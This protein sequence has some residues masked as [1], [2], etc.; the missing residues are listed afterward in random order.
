MS[1]TPTA[2]LLARLRRL[3]A[4]GAAPD[5]G[6]LPSIRELTGV[7]ERAKVGGLL[8]GVPARLL[9]GEG[10]PLRPLRV[11][12]TGTFT[13]DG[14]L[15]L[16]RTALLSAGIDAEILLTGYGRLTL[17]LGDPASPLAGFEPDV[18]LCLLHDEALLPHDWDPTDLA[19]LDRHV[20]ARAVEIGDLAADFAART[21]ATMLLHTV[22]L[23]VLEYRSL[24]AQRSRAAL[25]R[26]WRRANLVLLDLPERTQEVHVL[27]LE[28][29][30]ANEPVALRDE[31][32]YRF[33]RMAWSP[34][35]EDLYATEAAA[36]CRALTGLSRKVLALDLDQT[37]W[38]GVVGDDGPTGI[39]LGPLYPG[40][41]YLE[42][43][44][45]AK[46]LRRQGVLLAVCSKN[47]PEPVD[48]VFA[49]HP[50][51]VLQAEDFVAQAVNWLPK[52]ENLRELAHS[53]NLG[54]DSMVFFDDSAFE[55]ELVREALPDVRV[56]RANG[57]PADHAARLLGTG[58]FDVVR[59]TDTDLER[60]G[61]YRAEVRRRDGFAA[62]G[63]TRDFLDSL[64]LRVRVRPADPYAVP[65]V[66]Q[67]L[68]RTNQFNTTN[69]RW[70]A[71]QI[72][73]AVASDRRTVLVFDVADR[74]GSEDAVGAVLLSTAP[75]QWT[76]DNFVMS[77]RVFSRGIEFAVL[78]H[79]AERAA[80]RG[81]QRLVADFIPT[82]RNGPAAAF[83]RE[84]GF[85]PV[86]EPGQTHEL[87]LEPPPRPAPAWID[88][89]GE[90]T[91]SR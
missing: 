72:D 53:L 27:D 10:R 39:E 23:S 57:D 26:A 80:S 7:V 14:L 45:R 82:A 19:V 91:R 32:R 8:A 5:P 76:I 24:V 34:G 16:L 58:L 9:A 2:D 35:V 46:M 4:D 43:Q 48:R 55:C 66:H 64:E 11:G 12:L 70:T 31:R 69:L 40:N 17:D 71:A 84:A 21:G 52:D 78:H 54:L 77:C 90:T 81:A 22:P 37:L 65:R 30:V 75:E 28:T 88:L 61:R 15:P 74:F 87:L 86:D 13:A 60:T 42:V 3:T 73:E 36:F 68:H 50:A 47:S 20:A 18:V 6:L 1:G 25:G 79:V 29:L 62:A 33:A 44:R 63:G 59:L 85:T 51:M 83:I 38:G 89:E 41:A 56:V 49:E 67:L